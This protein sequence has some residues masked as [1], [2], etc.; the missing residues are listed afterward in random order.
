M[1][2]LGV[3]V[4]SWLKQEKRAFL[5]L[6]DGGIDIYLLKDLIP[7]SR[8]LSEHEHEHARPKPSLG[9]PSVKCQRVDGLPRIAYGTPG[10][11]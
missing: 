8:S 3:V 1:T 2:C 4:E 6:G 7:T 9:Q 5:G 11:S 10:H